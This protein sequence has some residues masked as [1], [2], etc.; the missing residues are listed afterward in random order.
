MRQSQYTNLE[1]KGFKKEIN[2][3]CKKRGTTYMQNNHN[4]MSHNDQH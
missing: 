4:Y 3:P 2:F 1:I